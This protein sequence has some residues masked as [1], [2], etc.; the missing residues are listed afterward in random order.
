MTGYSV[1]DGSFQG[2]ASPSGKGP[3]EA[4]SDDST[5]AS[6][7]HQLDGGIDEVVRRSGIYGERLTEREAADRL[8]RVLARNRRITEILERLDDS[9]FTSAD[10]SSICVILQLAGMVAATRASQISDSR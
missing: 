2:P 1:D 8:A 5:E 10:I 3:S 4:A 7:R 9:K 6:W